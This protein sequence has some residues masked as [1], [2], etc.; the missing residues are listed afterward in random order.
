MAPYWSAF[1]SAVAAS[2]ALIG[3]WLVL[4]A[5]FAVGSA[6][7]LRRLLPRAA[8]DNP[9]RRVAQN[10]AFPMAAALGNK[11]LDLLFAMVVLRVLG[12]SDVGHYAW[13]VVV[14]GYFDI[15]L[16]FGMNTWLTREVARAP[17]QLGRELGR[18]LLARVALWVALA[19]VAL[20]LVGPLA[21]PLAVTPAVGLALLL[22][23]LAEA[24]AG[25]STALSALFFARERMEYPAAV[26]V[27]SNVLKV[28]LGLLALALGY[29][30]VGLA[31]V[32][33]V[34][35]VV[36]LA[37][38]LTLFAD[39][40][41]RPR[42]AFAPA[43]SLSV[44]RD[45][46][47]FML[48]DLLASLFF[49]I[50]SLLLRPMAGSVALGWYSAA[51]RVVDGLGIIPAQFTLALFP[52]L[53][54]RGQTDPLALAR[55]YRRALKVLLVIAL[56]ASVG[57][58][59]LAEPLIGLFAG[60]AYVPESAWALRLLIWFLPFSFVN[61]VTQYVLIAVDRQRFLTI[62]FAVATAFN[63]AANLALIP[64]LSYLGAALVT[65]LS[66]VVLLGPFWWAVTRHLPPVSLLGVAWRP[67]L[68]A[69]GMAA[70]VA[71]L[72]ALT[73][74]SWLLSIP[75]GAAV[76]GALLLLLGTFDA[77]DRELLKRLRV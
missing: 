58:A 19:L 7:L 42:L 20:A 10:S 74:W 17:E 56:P 40:V 34:V 41:G 27:V 21:E 60:P 55:V 35:N 73:T 49:R 26:S 51:Y 48:N 77:A 75:V 64:Y 36:T 61:G 37:I 76:Y 29:S 4:A 32:A 24:P 45:S 46:Y 54:R 14:I 3:G 28:T 2:P 69:L 68:A 22:L 57:I 31:A 70:V 50:D 33:L 62:A 65:M 47:S 11:G 16:G 43:A 8:T 13:L 12:P 15:L 18:V 66:E 44:V 72:A 39:L 38:L 5:A 59:L 1:A 9:V 25:L 52:L 30:F 23:T 67:A 71:P 53:A 63:L 6:W